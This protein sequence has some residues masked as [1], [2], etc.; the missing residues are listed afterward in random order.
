MSG[1]STNRTNI[2][3]PAEVAQEILQKDGGDAPTYEITGQSGPPHAPVFRATVYRY[4]KALAEGEGKTKKQ[5]EQAAA[6]AA[7]QQI[8]KS[9]FRIQN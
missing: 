8:Q 2:N 6:L 5:A 4:G 9:E 1:I 3:P 7:L